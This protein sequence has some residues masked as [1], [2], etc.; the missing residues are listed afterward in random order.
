[1][2]TLKHA[3]T[4]EVT[5][6]SVPELRRQRLHAD[7]ASAILRLAPDTAERRPDVMAHHYTEAGQAPDAIPYWHQAG[8]RA[9]QGSYFTG[10]AAFLAG[11]RARGAA[12]MREGAEA[13]R[14]MHHR[15]GLR[16]RAELASALLDVGDPDD[17]A[18]AIEEALAQADEAREGAGVPELHR[19]RARVLLRRD[20]RDP[21]TVASLQE[22]L[23]M[24]SEQGAWLH[25]LRA[26]TEL[27]RLERQGAAGAASEAALRDVYARFGDDLDLPDLSAA[28]AL[29]EHRPL[30]DG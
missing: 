30:P 11:D 10:W 6:Q 2:L 16:L 13:Y 26:A 17:A 14:A 5:Y 20:P 24:A 15:A 4:H 1:M 12:V 28:R 22:A 8:Q 21:R 19:V 27:V 29:L 18:R 23:R 7:V 25:A 3:L 9:I